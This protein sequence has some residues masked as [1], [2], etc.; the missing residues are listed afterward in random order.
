MTRA[1]ESTA[2]Q[3][4]ITTHLSP[5]C[6]TSSISSSSCSSTIG[7]TTPS[8]ATASVLPAVASKYDLDLADNAGAAA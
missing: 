8:A 3:P 2:Q 1:A 7:A 5:C 6:N 4:A